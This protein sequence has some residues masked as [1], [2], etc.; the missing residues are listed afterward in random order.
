[1]PRGRVREARKGIRPA[2]PAMGGWPRT[3]AGTGLRRLVGSLSPDRPRSR[4]AC[5]GRRQWV[6]WPCAASPG[7]PRRARRRSPGRMRSSE[8]RHSRPPNWDTGRGLR[9][10][11]GYLPKRRPRR[12]TD[13]RLRAAAAPHPCSRMRPL[14]P[15]APAKPMPSPRAPAK[16]M[17]S[18]RAPATPALCLCPW[19]RAFLSDRCALYQVHRRLMHTYAKLFRHCG[20]HWAAH[21]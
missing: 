15:R 5:T 17:P 14:C 20:C 6:R 18:P 11:P 13:V 9:H 1:M 12:R 7:T 10:P 19:R 4:P 3:T 8:G 2:T 16:P 21:R